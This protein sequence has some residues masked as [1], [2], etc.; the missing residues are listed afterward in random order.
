MLEFDPHVLDEK[1]VP[2][3]EE[4]SKR[5]HVK[6]LDEYHKMYEWAERDPEGFWGEQSELLDWFVPPTRVLEWNLP[7]AKWFSDGKLNVSH[8]CLDRHLEEPRRATDDLFEIGGGIKFES[9]DDAKPR[10]QRRRQIGRAHV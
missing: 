7:H 9:M 8:N 10:A 5:A 4:F 1:P 6:S 3:P 2:P